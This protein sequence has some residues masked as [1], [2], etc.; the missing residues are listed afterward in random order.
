MTRRL[1]TFNYIKP[2]LFVIIL[3]SL[4]LLTGRTPSNAKRDT[5]NT[6]SE[7]PP[8]SDTIWV[9]LSPDHSPTGDWNVV[10]IPFD[11]G[12]ITIGNYE[13]DNYIRGVLAGEVSA[14]SIPEQVVF[15]SETLKAMAVAIRTKVYELC[16]DANYFNEFLDNNDITRH[17]VRGQEMQDYQYRKALVEY[18]SAERQRYQDAIDETDGEYLTY[19][20]DTFDIFY[21]QY[22]RRIYAKSGT[23]W[24]P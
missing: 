11:S 4:L 19:N 7:C 24:P 18:T 8:Q 23:K 13:Y 9:Q 17:G 12:T 22:R 2:I 10:E 3:A 20:G 6:W 21:P 16:G 5:I 14:T 15:D 1:R